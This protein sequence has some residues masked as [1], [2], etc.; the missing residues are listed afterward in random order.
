MSIFESLSN[1][2]KHTTAPQANPAQML[3]QLRNNPVGVLKQAGYNIP[4]GMNS[5]G[6][7]INYLL[8]SGQITN[9][10]LQMAQKMASGLFRR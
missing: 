3:Q 8:Q 6:Q 10:R 5:S 1:T 4:E 9:P 2:P 7:I